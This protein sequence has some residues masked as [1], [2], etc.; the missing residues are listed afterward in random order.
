MGNDVFNGSNFKKVIDPGNLTGI[1]NPTVPTQPG[2]GGVA[3]DARQLVQDPSTG[4]FYD[5]QTGT[6]Y[7]DPNGRNPVTDPNVAQQVASNFATRSQFLNQLSA[8]QPQQQA[9]AAHLNA[10]VNGQ[11]PS[12]AGMQAAQGMNQIANDQL[13]QT[14]GVGGPTAPLARLMAARNTAAA[15]AQANNAGTIGRVAEQN[16]AAGQLGGLLNT[17][18]GQNI[19]GA[20]TFSNQAAAGQAGQQNLN[21]QSNAANNQNQINQQNNTKQGLGALLGVLAA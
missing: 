3:S 17:M 21:Y 5:P 6:T 18:A 14:A 7:S 19:E 20:G 13:S 10:V 8:V 1:N 11:A 2:V 15:Q 16:A 9:L 12:V 4:M